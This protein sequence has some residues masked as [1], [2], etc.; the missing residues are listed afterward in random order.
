MLK[1][2]WPYAIV[3]IILVAILIAKFV[4]WPLLFLAAILAILLCFLF[5]E[6]AL[7]LFAFTLPLEKTLSIDIGGF[8]FRFSHFL[9]GA[10]AVAWLVKSLLNKKLKIFWNQS[11]VFLILYLV[12]AAISLRDV[13]NLN[14]GWEVFIF[15]T[16]AIFSFWFLFQL[17]REQPKRIIFFLK[18]LFI[19]A[20]AVG[21]FGLL[22]ISGDLLNL[23]IWLTGIGEGYTKGVLGFPRVRAS[24]F[25]P[26]YFGSFII[27]I[28]PLVY[29]QINSVKKLISQKWL[30]I[31]LLLLLINLIL[32]FAR[33][34]YLAFAVEVLIV[35]IFSIK[36]IF[37]KKALRFLSAF[38]LIFVLFLFVFLNFPKIFPHKVQA[39]L[40]HTVETTDWSSFER[41]NSGGLALDLFREN[42]IKG[43]GLGQF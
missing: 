30:K 5:F 9:I 8:T 22:Q 14:R 7:M 11:L 15:T 27:L 37:Q 13:V 17:F 10:L 25:E 28:L 39:A 20:I 34:A 3:A 19:S 16:F 6:K 38:T 41:L 26:L 32:T 23:P 43:I 33:S 21:I 42:P 1:N 35:A 12:V 2:W 31:L 24:F 18:T 29:M 40:K 4:F 36:F